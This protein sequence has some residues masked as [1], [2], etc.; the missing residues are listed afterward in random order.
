MA[1]SWINTLMRPIPSIFPSSF[2]RTVALYNARTMRTK[3]KAIGAHLWTS[4]FCYEIIHLNLP[5]Y[6]FQKRRGP[7]KK[8]TYRK[9]CCNSHQRDWHHV[10]KGV[11]FVYTKNTRLLVIFHYILWLPWRQLAPTRKQ[12]AAVLI[13]SCLYHLCLYLC[14]VDDRSSSLWEY[15]ANTLKSRIS[16]RIYWVWKSLEW[17]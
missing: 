1:W 12:Y 8:G 14:H 17:G 10:F 7:A 2:H 16:T 15:R 3:P 11:F 9:V 4:Q 6:Y 13:F 5:L